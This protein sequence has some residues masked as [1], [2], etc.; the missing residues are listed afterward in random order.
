[1]NLNEHARAIEE[2]LKAAAD[3]GFYLD[4]SDE[5]VPDLDLNDYTGKSTR[6]VD[7]I[8]PRLR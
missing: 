4:N 1:M 8:V 3:D 6:W 7:L 5:T 2:V